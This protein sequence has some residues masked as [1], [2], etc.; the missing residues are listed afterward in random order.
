[1]LHDK[2]YLEPW[3]RGTNA[4]KS[5]I[6]RG[7]LH[8]L[9]MA[10]EDVPMAVEGLTDQEYFD[11][12]F[13]LNN[14]SFHVQHV[15]GSCDRLL[16]YARGEELTQQQRDYAAQENIEW[17]SKAAQMDCFKAAMIAYPYMVE[18]LAEG[19]LER[20]AFVGGKRIPTTVGAL[21]IH[22]AEHTSRHV[23]QLVTTAKLEMAMR[24]DRPLAAAPLIR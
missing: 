8:A 10:A 15:I 16:A 9:E 13:G 14:A 5:F 4:D 2:D 18:Q 23:G 19:D 11:R 12:P 24:A 20:A 1:M 3:L 21:L 6:I 7:V 22:V 17:G